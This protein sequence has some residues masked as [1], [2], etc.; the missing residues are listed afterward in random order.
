M[1]RFLY[2]AYRQNLRR[3]YAKDK[4]KTTTAK[5]RNIHR[6]EL[7]FFSLPARLYVYWHHYKAQRRSRYETNTTVEDVK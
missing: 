3:G 6:L 2:A 1:E 5:G 4:H 7:A